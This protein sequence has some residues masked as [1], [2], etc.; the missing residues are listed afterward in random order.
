[1]EAKAYTQVYFILQMLSVEDKK[2]IPENLIIGIKN[3]MDKNYHFD[4]EEDNETE[5]LED[6]EKLLSVIYTDYLATKEERNII[7]NIELKYINEREIQKQK[8]YSGDVFEEK[9]KRLEHEN[10]FNTNLLF[11]QKKENPKKRNDILVE[12]NL[13]DL[14]NYSSNKESTITI[15]KNKWYHKLFDFIRGI[16]II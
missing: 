1:M 16:F 11:N 15:Y 2:K 10:N 7:K 4:I 6:T 12:G 5:L 14:T 8:K 3:K 9:R 13:K